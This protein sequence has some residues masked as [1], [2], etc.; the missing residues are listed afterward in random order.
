MKN[1]NLMTM[2]S[3]VILATVISCSKPEQKEVE[4]ENKNPIDKK[5][6]IEEEKEVEPFKAI[7]FAPENGNTVIISGEDV[8]AAIPVEV[9][10]NKAVQKITF[11][12]E[13]LKEA[14]NVALGSKII[15][16]TACFYGDYYGQKSEILH[17]ENQF[18][19]EEASAIAYDRIYN[20]TTGKLNDRVM[21]INKDEPK[22]VKFFLTYLYKTYYDAIGDGLMSFKIPAGILQFEE[23]GVLTLNE[24]INFDY[25][26]KIR[27]KRDAKTTIINSYL[28]PKSA[29]IEIE[30][31]SEYDI[32]DGV[33]EVINIAD[34]NIV[35]TI[36]L[37]DPKV[38]VTTNEKFK[39]E[40]K[41][42]QSL[43]SY[44]H[45]TTKISFPKEQFTGLFSLE[46]SKGIM[47][48]NSGLP[49]NDHLH[50][51][52]E[53]IEEPVVIPL[54]RPL[55]VDINETAPTVIITPGD[56]NLDLKGK[57]LAGF[58]KNIIIDFKEPIQKKGEIIITDDV[59]HIHKFKITDCLEKGWFKDNKLTIPF[60]EIKDNRTVKS[61]S[62]EF[63]DIADYGNNE[64]TNKTEK[65]NFFVGEQK[66][67]T[68]NISK[69]QFIQ[70]EDKVVDGKTYKVYRFVHDFMLTDKCGEIF[71]NTSSSI[72]LNSKWM[73]QTN[74]LVI[75]TKT[76]VKN[77]KSQLYN[78]S[79]LDLDT[80]RLGENTFDFYSE[81]ELTDGSYTFSMYIEAFGTDKNNPLL[82]IQPF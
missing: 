50:R 13:E 80:W 10:F 34:E 75:N 45:K 51:F 43:K 32:K 78:H 76:I 52:T 23:D 64:P 11:T 67:I 57:K 25:Y 60:K 49:F 77:G 37:K 36:E 53:V 8:I 30:L 17:L 59:K 73:K 18:T 48:P 44:S 42:F 63:I 19:E 65:I 46:F 2:V 4:P 39:K 82:A 9:T 16:Q 15:R 54:K 66:L 62:Y 35:Q 24:E 22:K 28:S 61:L 56:R 70:K 69:D 79:G 6:D 40:V 68:F 1:I 38:T 21:I 72:V 26:L 29:N 71:Q 7:S 14:N 58:F 12:D 31:S 5:E 47:I 27:R 81:N 74:Y 41:L 20:E 3:C 33:I 55:Y